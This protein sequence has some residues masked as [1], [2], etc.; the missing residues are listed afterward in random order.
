[1]AG[2]RPYFVYYGGKW[3]AAPRYPAPCHDTI[4]EPFAGS[5]GY[6]LRYPDRKVVLVEKDAIL[7]EL[8]RYLIRATAP[9]FLGLP[10]LRDGETTDDLRICDG[11]RA[12]IGFWLN[13]GVSSPRKSPSAWMR[14]GVRPKSYWGPEVRAMLA[15]QAGKIA[16]WQ[17]IEGDY[18]EAP[19]TLATW[20]VDPP[21]VGAGHMYRHGPKGIDYAALASWCL[22]RSGQVMVCENSGATWLPFK[23]HLVAKSLPGSRGKG[24]S[25][26]ALW[27]SAA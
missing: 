24:H 12:L 11:A 15:A 7:A 6:A 26:E 2:I 1:M 18:T 20:F 8:W 17:I 9:D 22:A 27:S 10:D 3:R 19:D 4:I 25:N 13:K 5:A 21:Y 23:E 16:H 14:S